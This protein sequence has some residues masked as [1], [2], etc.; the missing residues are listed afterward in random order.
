MLQRKLKH[1]KK[2]SQNW[3]KQKAKI[4]HRY[5]TQAKFVCV[6]C[7]YNNNVDVVGAINVLTRG[8]SRARVCELNR[9]VRR[10]AA[11]TRR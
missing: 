10:S 8:L 7:G 9:A 2:F 3:L 1:K 4:T 5:L 6:E 11:E